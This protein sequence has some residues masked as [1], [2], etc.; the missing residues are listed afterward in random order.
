MLR[1]N[2][3]VGEAPLAKRGSFP[4]HGP[5]DRRIRGD[6]NP[7]GALGLGQLCRLRQNCLVKVSGRPVRRSPSSLNYAARPLRASNFDTKSV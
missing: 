7:N 3:A 5:I 2:Q 4:R 1:A 6:S